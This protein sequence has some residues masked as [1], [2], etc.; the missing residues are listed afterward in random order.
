MSTLA[1]LAAHSPPRADPD[2]PL[3]LY[4]KSEERYDDEELATCSGDCSMVDNWFTFAPASSRTAASLGRP[5][6]AAI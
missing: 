2:S 5:Y 6:A 1:M 4:R 3:A